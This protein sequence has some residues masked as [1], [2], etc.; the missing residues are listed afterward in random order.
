MTPSGHGAPLWSYQ[1]HCA[2]A[3]AAETESRTAMDALRL[4]AKPCSPTMA[5]L[6]LYASYC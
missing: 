2:A 4:R 6:E 1:G 5:A 3:A